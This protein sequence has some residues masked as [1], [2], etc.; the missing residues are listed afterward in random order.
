MWM[1]QIK[2]RGL[3]FQFEAMWVIQ[4][5][6]RDVLQFEAL[7]VEYMIKTVRSMSETEDATDATGV[8]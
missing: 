2:A 6:A 4:F 1:V 5:M 3:V 8:V 7:G